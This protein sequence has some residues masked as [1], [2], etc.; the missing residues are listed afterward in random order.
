MV[1]K[2]H[3]TLISILL[4]VTVWLAQSLIVYVE[5]KHPFHAPDSKC[6][7]CMQAGQ[8]AHAL[9]NTDFS[10][11]TEHS[12]PVYRSVPVIGFSV[13]FISSYLIRGPPL[14]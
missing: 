9:V 10:L 4:A 3:K 7:I 14:L 6:E 1:M 2:Q 13:E 5:Y 12:V 8:L 11:S